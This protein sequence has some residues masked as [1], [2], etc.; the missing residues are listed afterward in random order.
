MKSFP[1]LTCY[2]NYY[3]ILQQI[4]QYIPPKGEFLPSNIG[5][6]GLWIVGVWDLFILFP[7]STRNRDVGT[8]VTQINNLPL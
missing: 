6:I 3:S 8:P 5:R 4:L 1:L 7:E 2:N